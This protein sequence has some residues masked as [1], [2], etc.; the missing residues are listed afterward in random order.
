MIFDIGI[1]FLNKFCSS[2]SGQQNR[3]TVFLKEKEHTEIV[4][5]ED[6]TEC[7]WSEKKFNTF[8]YKK[9]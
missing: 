3:L 7:D 2:L 8:F 5:L 1:L 4:F 9:K 6:P